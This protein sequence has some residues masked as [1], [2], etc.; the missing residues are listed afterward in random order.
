MDGQYI[1]TTTR[2]RYEY[3]RLGEGL[4]PAS[5]ADAFVKSRS[6]GNDLPLHLTEDILALQQHLFFAQ[7]ALSGRDAKAKLH[8]IDFMPLS[9]IVMWINHE[10]RNSEKTWV[11][12]DHMCWAFLDAYPV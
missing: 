8:L 6:V 10:K 4:S 5:E 9:F 3:W 1:I 7:N 2:C 11:C 12:Y